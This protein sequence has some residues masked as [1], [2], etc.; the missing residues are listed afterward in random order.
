[1]IKIDNLIVTPETPLEEVQ[2]ALRGAVGEEVQITTSRPPDYSE[3]IRV[4]TR[5]E[6]PLPSVVW[7]LDTA[8]SRLGIIQINLI[9]S[10]TQEEVITAVD[11]LH[12]RGA[13]AYVLDLR[14]NSGGLLDAGIDISRLFL[15]SGTIIEQQYRGQ[16]SEIFSVDKPG[17]LSQLPLVVLV[18]HNTA[19]AA[20]IIAGSLQANHRAILIGA[21]TFGKDTI[22]LV[23]NLDDGSS[24]HVTAA[25]WWIPYLPEPLADHGLRPDILI[26]PMHESEIDPFIDAA[27]AHFF[28][29]E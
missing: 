27:I 23:F 25:H 29:P 12:T 17:E 19:S 4:I 3:T 6:I 2:A 16:P 21:P 13:T 24:L 5:E 9:A 10:T 15:T 14:N 18:N 8:E 20:E 1:M 7:H 26:D 28:A 11:D 22:Q